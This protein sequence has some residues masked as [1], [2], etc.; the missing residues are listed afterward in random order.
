MCLYPK[1]IKNKRYR[2]NAKNQGDVPEPQDKRVLF[3]PAACGKCMQCRK[4]KSREWAVRLSEEIRHDD[5]GKF[6]TFT[7]SDKSLSDLTDAIHNDSKR[8]AKLLKQNE[9]GL[10]GYNLDNE[11]ATIAMRYFLER[12]RKKYKKSVKHWFVTELGGKYTERIHL[13]GILWTDVDIDTIANIWKYG[14]IV[15]GDGKGTHYVNERTVNYMIKYVHKTDIKHPEYQQKIL[16]SAG[17]GKGYLD[18]VD[19]NLNHFNPNGT[20]DYYICRNGNKLPLPTYYRRKIYSDDERESLWL[21]LLDKETRYVDGIEVDVS[22]SYDNYYK[23]L[24]EARKKN[25]VLGYGDDEV[26][27]EKR[28]Y[29]NQKRMLKRN[30]I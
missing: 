1:L 3:V 30:L 6:I 28:Y 22:E 24:A 7:F 15:L 20:R 21:E 27:W 17:I 14:H 26:N 23:L 8:M 5:R 4:Q 2:V 12:W 13:H 16:T 9:N 10:S 25:K 11:I 29:E 19:S 18:R